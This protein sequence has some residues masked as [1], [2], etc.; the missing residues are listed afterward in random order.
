MLDG[1]QRNS[2]LNGEGA[3]GA[4]RRLSSIS[5]CHRQRVLSTFGVAESRR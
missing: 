5:R 4:A 1:F 3:E 2:D